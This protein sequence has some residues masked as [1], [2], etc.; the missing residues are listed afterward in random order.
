MVVD[1]ERDKAAVQQP[2]NQILPKLFLIHKKI[3]N[4]FFIA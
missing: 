3:S 1:E 2:G 4:M